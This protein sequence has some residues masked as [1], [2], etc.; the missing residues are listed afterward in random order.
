MTD[1]LDDLTRDDDLGDRSSEGTTVVPPVRPTPAKPGVG[2]GAGRPLPPR[3]AVANRP[4]SV[5]TAAGPR[6]DARKKPDPRPMR[7]AYGAGALAA[8]SAMS[9]GLVRFGS[10]S[11]STPAAATTVTNAANPSAATQTVAV[12]HVVRY[13]HLQP[14]QAAPPGAKVIQPNAPAPKVVVSYAAGPAAAAPR[15]VIV[16]TSQ[17]GKP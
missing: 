6:P 17:S 11:A 16:V 3:P 4:A 7:L 8:M 12:K 5:S 13:I 14:G 15:R 9:V 2:A 10:S 1:V